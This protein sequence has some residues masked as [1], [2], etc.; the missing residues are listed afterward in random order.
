M[1][2]SSSMTASSPSDVTTPALSVRA[3][4]VPFGF[5][6]LL[7]LGSAPCFALRASEQNDLYLFVAIPLLAFSA[8]WTLVMMR[9][10]LAAWRTG[11]IT[12][13]LK[14]WPARLGEEVTHTVSFTSKRTITL[15]ELTCKLTVWEVLPA[16]AGGIITRDKLHEEQHTMSAEVVCRGGEVATFSISFTL[17][18]SLPPTGKN[19]A[20]EIVWQLATDLSPRR[21]AG[22]RRQRDL[23]AVASPVAPEPRD[24]AW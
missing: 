23:L 3:L 10:V 1:H 20:R 24:P 6:A 15:R 21:G 14:P 11:P 4:L 5:G 16:R 9:G 13:Q 22:Q 7:A 8:V 19:E 18:A 2:P 17:P 12:Q